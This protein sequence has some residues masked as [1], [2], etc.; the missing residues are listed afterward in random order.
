VIMILTQRFGL[1]TERFRLGME[2]GTVGTERIDEGIVR[3]LSRSVGFIMFSS[4]LQG[5]N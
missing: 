4:T 2:C 3:S 1:G 5:P